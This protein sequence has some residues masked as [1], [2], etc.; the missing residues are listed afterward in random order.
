[1]LPSLKSLQDPIFLEIQLEGD[2]ETVLLYVGRYKGTN[3]WAGLLSY[4]VFT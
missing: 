1:M 3:H 2:S 4:G